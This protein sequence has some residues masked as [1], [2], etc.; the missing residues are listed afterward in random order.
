MA[1]QSIYAAFERMWQHILA[2]VGQKANVN[3]T[4]EDLY[5]T[6]TEVD[7]K[8]D[9]IEESLQEVVNNIEVITNS[10]IDTLFANHN[11]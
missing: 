6:Q 4:H 8:I 1:N 7:T 5:Y 3:H 2:V 9:G 11:L 10:E